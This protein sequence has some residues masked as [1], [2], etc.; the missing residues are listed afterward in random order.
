M[1]NLRCRKVRALL[2]EY[3]LDGAALSE[4]DRHHLDHC[5]RCQAEVAGYRTL[6]RALEAF[7][8]TSADA[9]PWLVARIMTQLGRPEPSQTPR[10]AAGVAVALVVA[11]AAVAVWGR[12][13]LRPAH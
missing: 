8:H 4:T 7:G 10:R 11:G 13:L 12:R 2:A 6:A 3:V 1:R 9:P 5:L